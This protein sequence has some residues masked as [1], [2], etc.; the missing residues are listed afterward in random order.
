MISLC[1]LIDL[2]GSSISTVLIAHWQLMERKIR[3]KFNR[4]IWVDFL[5]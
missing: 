1:S 3:V 4:F 2:V 5:V